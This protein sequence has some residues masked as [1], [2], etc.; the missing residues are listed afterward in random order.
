MAVEMLRVVK[1]V[2]PVIF[3]DAGPGCLA[4]PCPEGSMTCGKVAEVRKRF[5]SM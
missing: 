3:R 5:G 2:A 1:G 4:G